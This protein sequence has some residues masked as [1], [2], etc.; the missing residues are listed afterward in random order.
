M[1]L[2]ILINGMVLGGIYAIL[3]LGFSLVF[4]VAKILNM[5]HTGFY[6][7]AGFLLLIVM[8]L[9]RLPVQ[10]S[11]VP[12]VLLTALL[13]VVCYWLVFDR[14]KEH[15][16][17]VM[18]IT[19][20][21]AMLFQEVLQLKYGEDFRRVDPFIP[22]FF[23]FSGINISYQQLLAIGTSLATLAGVGLL[24]SKTRLGKAIK[25]VSQDM[26]IANLMGIDV[27]R[28]CL[29]TMGI[30]TCLAGVACAVVAPIFMVHSQMWLPPL[31]IVLAAVVLGGLGSIKGSVIAAFILGFAETAVVFLVPGGS[32]LRGAV[33]LG[34]MVAVLLV[35]PEG[36]FGVVF[37]EERL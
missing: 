1:A 36:L 9:L 19:I 30:S 26:E 37:E 14:V 12:A 34:T 29:I 2:A 15:E 8:S 33:S 35:K 17:A 5:A 22:G 21:L 7:V 4:G 32:F 24:L 18:I 3:T 11:L 31:L 16:T 23:E 10:P 13:G 27:S 20:A 25:A 6:M 28:I